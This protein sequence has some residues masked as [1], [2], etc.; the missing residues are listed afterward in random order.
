MLV[1]GLDD[2]HRLALAEV[3]PEVLLLA[4]AVV[5]DEI[6]GGLEDRVR[7]PVVLLERDHLRRSGSRARTPG[8]CGCRRRGSRRRL[9][10]VADRHQVLMLAGEQLQ[11]HVLRVVR[12]LVLVDHH[13]PER[14][15]PAL[16]RLGEALQDVDGQHQHVVEVDGVRC[17][18]L[19]LVE[20][21]HVGD[22]LVV[23]ARDP[24]RVLVRPD[25]LVLRIRDL[26]VDAARNEALRVALELLEAHLDDAA[27]GRP[28][29]RS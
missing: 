16:A 11:Q 23:E 14:L 1:L 12:V 20:R 10:R 21:V 22:G 19:A 7:R 13:V 17:E 26:R 8:C 27:P 28:S 2:P 15:R 9:I 3:R 4:L 25:Q 24:R 29:R 5:R 18:E 6:V